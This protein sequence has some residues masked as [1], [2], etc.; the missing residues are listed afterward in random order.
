[1]TQHGSCAIVAIGDELLLGEIQDSNSSYLAQVISAYG[2]HVK[3]MAIIG[4]E[5]ERIVADLNALCQEVDLI[6]VTGGLG[7]TLDDRTRHALAALTGTELREHKTAWKQIESYYKKHWPAREMPPSNKRQALIPRGVKV[8]KNDRGT[9]PGM[10][11]QVNG[12]YI[13]CMPGVPH[14]MKAMAQRFVGNLDKL[15]P[16]LHVPVLEEI[17]FAGLG[18]SRAQDMLGSLLMGNS[19]ARIQVGICAHEGG[20]ITIRVRG[21]AAKVRTHA[22]KIRKILKH[23]VLPCSGLAESIVQ[24]L[25]KRKQ[26]L[27]SAESCTCGHIVAAIGA[28]A[29]ASAVLRESLIAYH[30]DVKVERLDVNPSLIKKYGVVSEEVVEAMAEGALCRSNADFAIATSG[31]AG[32]G[33]GSAKKP[34]GTV[35][36][37]VAAKHKMLTQRLS[38]RGDRVR[39]QQRAAAEALRLLW[40]LLIE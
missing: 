16:E 39:I 23:S 10:L 36:V 9:A 29:G 13:V 28:I 5:E 14:E 2:F 24:E 15:F 12:T 20:H 26:T 6:F 35:W 30:N 34:V 31:I 8:L 1:M 3:S 27:T 19:A 32:P 7:P 40:Q 21:P 18:E 4:D 17:H 33:G 25:T 22:Q 38:V 37:A 11:A